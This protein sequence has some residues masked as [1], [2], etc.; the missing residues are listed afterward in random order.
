LFVLVINYPQLGKI[1]ESLENAGF[2][3]HES[4]VVLPFFQTVVAISRLILLQLINCKLRNHTD[5]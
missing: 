1:L 3:V 2:C 5:I 4:A